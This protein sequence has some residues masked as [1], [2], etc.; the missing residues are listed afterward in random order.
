MRHTRLEIEFKPGSAQQTGTFTNPQAILTW[1]D[2][3]GQTFGNDHFASLGQSGQT[4]NRCIWR[5]LGIARDRV[6]QVT[7]SD[8]VNRDIVGASIMGEPYRT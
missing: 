2:D 6:Y 5:R 3:G 1:S 4:K 8:P 7:V